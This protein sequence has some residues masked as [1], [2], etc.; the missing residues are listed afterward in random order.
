MP[1]ASKAAFR[2][3]GFLFLGHAGPIT[4]IFTPQ[5]LTR[6]EQLV[7]LY[8][9]PQTPQ[10]FAAQPELWAQAEVIIATWGCTALTPAMVAAAPLLKVIFHAGGSSKHLA[11]PTRP[12]PCR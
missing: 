2:P 8:A 4:D 10:T 3:K 1:S 9:P 12:T 11:A 6:L 7:D 5:D